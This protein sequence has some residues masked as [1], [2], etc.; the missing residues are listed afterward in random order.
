MCSE[1]VLRDSGQFCNLSEVVIRPNDTLETLSNKIEIA[2]IIGTLQSSL[3]N[4]RYLRKVWRNNCEE[5]RLLG[6]S[7]T[8]IMDHPVMNGSEGNDKLISWLEQLK[9]VSQDVNDELSALL[10]IN[11]S[12][13]INAVK[14]SGT[15]SQ[16]VDTASGIHPRY[17][18]YY[19][20]TVRADNK[21]PLAILMMDKGVPFEPDITKPNTTVIFSFPIKSPEGSVF[22]DDRTA[23]D[24]LELWK[25]YQLHYCEHKPSITIYV[26][27]N[28][29]LEVAS[30]VYNNFDILSGVSFLPHSNHNY[31]QAPYQEIEEEEYYKE[32]ENVVNI[33]WDDLSEYEKTDQTTSM[34]EYACTGNSCE[35]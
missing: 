18:P 34:K 21:D 25:V 19:I 20:R 24:Q 33:N 15:V 30:W 16:L 4:F 32:L 7:L 2:T 26:K 29:W 10:G 31:K 14:P 35:L 8:G 22:R 9:A 3:T 23:I 11:P 6:V 28:E 17:S 13:A 12:T 5:E 27:E 1:I